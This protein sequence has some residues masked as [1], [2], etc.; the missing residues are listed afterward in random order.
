MDSLT[1]GHTGAHGEVVALGHDDTHDD[2]AHTQQDAGQ[3]TGHEQRA[4]GHAARSQRIDDHVMA[5]RNEHALAGGG[6][7]QADGK[8]LVVSL[9]LH[10]RDHDRAQRGHVRHGG[11]GDAAE[12]HG[13]KHVHIGQT[14]AETAHSQV[15]QVDNLLGDAARTHELAHDDKERNGK[16]REVVGAIHHLA[17][18]DGEV[19]ARDQCAAQRGG[20]HGKRNRGSQDHQQ[21]ESSDEDNAGKRRRHLASS[22]FCMAATAA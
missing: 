16:Q 14:A 3:Q 5:G 18:H 17:Y 2:H 1:L 6:D 19:G 10:H 7:G 8:I 13:V 12:E 15:G 22:S 20:Q 21:H 4:D 11:A 9:L